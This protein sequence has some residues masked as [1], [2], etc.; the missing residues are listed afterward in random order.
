MVDFDIPAGLAGGFVATVVMT[1]LMTM[2]ARAGMTAMPPMP[3]VTGSMFSGDRRRATTIGALAHY[4]MMGTVLFG[5]GYAALFTAFDNDAWWVG[6]LLGVAHGLVV[7][8]MAMPMM[9]AIHPRMTSDPVTLGGSAGL[10]TVGVDDHGQVEITA[11]GVLGINWGRMTPAGLLMGHAVYG[12]V[13]AVV[14]GAI[15]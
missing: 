14:Y 7:G 6:A 10:S 5:L 11:P 13:L 8:L 3:L 12:L 4:V 15:A 9:P 1:A 2:A